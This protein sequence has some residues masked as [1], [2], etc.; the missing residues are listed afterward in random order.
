[1]ITFAQSPGNRRQAFR[2]QLLQVGRKSRLK[3]YAII[4]QLT[5]SVTEGTVQSCVLKERVFLA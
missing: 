4:L 3:F 2:N 5:I 1:M